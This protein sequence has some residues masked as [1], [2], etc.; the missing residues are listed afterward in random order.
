MQVN[1]IEPMV[2]QLSPVQQG[3]KIGVHGDPASRQVDLKAEPP[4]WA[5]RAASV[6]TSGVT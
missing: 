3:S 6:R 1:A 4:A 5:S 2:G